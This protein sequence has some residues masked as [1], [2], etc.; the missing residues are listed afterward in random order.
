MINGNIPCTKFE[1]KCFVILLVIE[2]SITK[3]LNKVSVTIKL[4]ELCYN[5]KMIFRKS[6]LYKLLIYIYI[7]L[8]KQDI[9][10][11]FLYSLPDGWIEWDGIF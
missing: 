1:M 9:R 4:L 5:S 8:V 6:F 11:S 3:G 2:S 7:Y 10:F